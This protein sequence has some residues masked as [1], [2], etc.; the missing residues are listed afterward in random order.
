MKSK[1]TPGRKPAHSEGI[2][3]E[4]GHATLKTAALGAD[5][6]LPYPRPLSHARQGE[7]FNQ[8]TRVWECIL[9]HV[10]RHEGDPAATYA[11]VA[12]EIRPDGSETG[13]KNGRRRGELRPMT[14]ADIC[15][16]LDI[17]KGNV[18]RA[19][20]KLVKQGVLRQEGRTKLHLVG[21]PDTD[22]RSTGGTKVVSTDNLAPFL[23]PP[24]HPCREAWLADLS[25]L[26]Q[27]LTATFNAALREL[28]ATRRADTLK[29]HA[30]VAASYL[31]V[32]PADLIHITEQAEKSTE[33]APAPT[34]EVAGTDNSGPFMVAGIDNPEAP[35][36]VSTRDH[37]NKE[38]REG[39]SAQFFSKTPPRGLAGHSGATEQRES[40]PAS[41]PGPFKKNKG[42][43]ADKQTDA[44]NLKQFTTELNQKFTRRFAAP[45]TGKWAAEIL[46]RLKGADWQ[47]LFDLLTRQQHIHSWGGVALLADECAS[48]QDTWRE[49]EPTTDQPRKSRSDQKRNDYLRRKSE[50]ESNG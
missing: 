32:K 2:T 20:Q 4:A 23:P 50:E 45:A 33:K 37:I 26:N 7:D 34:P 40:Q 22:V 43:T 9:Y 36:V 3:T 28:R 14:Q 18:S 42:Q 16:I 27:Q 30:E 25:Q 41:Q 15:I 49:A 11:Q 8:E 5:W 46:K 44:E 38:K 10:L 1:A 21:N 24:S 6:F 47:Q 29:A 19:V 17:D 48:T 35:S 31:G 12:G 39:E 13:I